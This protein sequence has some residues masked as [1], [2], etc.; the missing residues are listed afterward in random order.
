MTHAGQKARLKR[1]VLL[2]VFLFL[3]NAFLP[4][5]STSAELSI[6]SCQKTTK[7]LK[8]KREIVAQN[9]GVWARFES[10]G[11]LRDQS[12]TALRLDSRINSLLVTLDYICETLN[13][14]PL[15]EL[16]IFVN[17]SI[18]RLGMEGFK[19][20][21]VSLGKTPTEVNIWIQF[22]QYAKAIENRALDKVSVSQTF[23]RA[24]EIVDQYLNL[25]EILSAVNDVSLALKDTTGLLARTDKFFIDDPTAARVR[26]ELSKVPFWDVDENYGGS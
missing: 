16:A 17:R 26:L 5:S 23:Q 2:L 9:G 4:I 20:H 8:S 6:K 11:A 21:Q 18:S 1:S 13:G 25:W 24:E 3:Q 12:L 7:S 22:A 15:N 14:V 10:V 19:K